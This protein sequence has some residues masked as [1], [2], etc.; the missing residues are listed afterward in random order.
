MVDSL[1]TSARS[2][3]ITSGSD[4]ETLARFRERYHIIEK[5]K[6]NSDIKVYICNRA[7]PIPVLN[8]GDF[9]E[10]MRQYLM[11]KENRTI[12][13]RD[14]MFNEYNMIEQIG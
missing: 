10:Y 8:T 2:I 11:I 13:G 6:D 14:R 12:E 9:L 4:D 7:G 5:L 3:T 1:S